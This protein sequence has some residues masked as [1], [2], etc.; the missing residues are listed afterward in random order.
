MVNSSVSRRHRNA[1][2]VGYA[3]MPGSTAMRFVHDCWLWLWRCAQSR[4]AHSLARVGLGRELPEMLAQ[5]MALCRGAVY[6]ATNQT[7]T[8]QSH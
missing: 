8:R 2:V 5:V 1:R 7:E 4:F 6:H 3:Y